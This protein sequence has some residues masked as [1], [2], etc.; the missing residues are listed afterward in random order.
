MLTIVFNAVMFLALVQ[1][2]LLFLTLFANKKKIKAVLVGIL[3]LL[4]IFTNFIIF[5][6]EILIYFILRVI[7]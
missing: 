5:E 2:L 1:S 3:F 6:K 4:F 7:K